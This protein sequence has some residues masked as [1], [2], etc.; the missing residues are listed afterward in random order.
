MPNKD[1]LTRNLMQ[2]CEYVRAMDKVEGH[3]LLDG[4]WRLNS[5]TQLAEF[6]DHFRNIDLARILLLRN[7]VGIVQA[8]LI[9]KSLHDS[10]PMPLKCMPSPAKLSKGLLGKLRE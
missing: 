9:D 1:K 3:D 5:I 2:V 7:N 6:E 4:G 8:V 10:S